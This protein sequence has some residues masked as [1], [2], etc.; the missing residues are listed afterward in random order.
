VQNGRAAVQ[1]PVRAGGTEGSFWHRTFLEPFTGLNQSKHSGACVR[2]GPK[3]MKERKNDWA[4]DD[5]MTLSSFGS[6]KNLARSEQHTRTDTAVRV[7]VYEY[8]VVQLYL[9]T[10]YEPDYESHA[11]LRYTYMYDSYPLAGTHL[12]WGHA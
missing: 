10:K 6:D 9:N 1:L 5:A 4:C 8:D 3:A 2:P 12:V 11:W 7:Q